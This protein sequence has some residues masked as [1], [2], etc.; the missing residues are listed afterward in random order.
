M[1][2]YLLNRS[3][4]FWDE[5]A[6]FVIRAESARRAREIADSKGGDENYEYSEVTDEME[7]IYPWKDRRMSSCKEITPEGEEGIILIDFRAG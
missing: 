2:L 3:D 4:P 1:K 7:R 5:K 6:G